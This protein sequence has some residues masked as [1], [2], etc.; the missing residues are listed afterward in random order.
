M[1]AQLADEE[2][3]E[4]NAFWNQEFF[5]GEVQQRVGRTKLVHSRSSGGSV[6]RLTHSC[7][8]H[9]RAEDAEDIDYQVSN[10]GGSK[11]RSQG[12]LPCRPC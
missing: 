12:P 7:P 2:A 3:E 6:H 9:N 4:D 11:T 5:A 10:R 8:S 1:A